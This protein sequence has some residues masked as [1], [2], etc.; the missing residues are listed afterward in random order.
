MSLGHDLTLHILFAQHFCSRP[1]GGHPAQ[2]SHREPQAGNW[3]SGME[4][5]T[6]CLVNPALP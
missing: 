2:R 1:Q 5:E 6:L 3:N 4:I